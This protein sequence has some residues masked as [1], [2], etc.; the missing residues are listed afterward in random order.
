MDEDDDDRPMGKP[1]KPMEE[2]K[3]AEDDDM[4][5]KKKTTKKMK[6]RCTRMTWKSQST[7]M[8]PLVNTGL[9]GEHFEVLGV[10][11]GAARARFDGINKA[12]LGSTLSKLMM[13]QTTLQ[14][15]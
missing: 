10:D 15:K 11:T 12:N 4:A 3:L 14:V 8:S 5:K 2:L 7:A 13:E 1:K 6:R 9:D